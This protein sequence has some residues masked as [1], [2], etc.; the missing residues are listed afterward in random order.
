MFLSF[1]I[2]LATLT[3][4]SYEICWLHFSCHSQ[5]SCLNLNE[6]H[7]RKSNG[8]LEK[9]FCWLKLEVIIV[10]IK[11]TYIYETVIYEI[12]DSTKWLKVCIKIL[13]MTLINY[14]IFHSD[15]W[16]CFFG[17]HLPFINFLLLYST[18]SLTCNTKILFSYY[19]ILLSRSRCI[20]H[21]SLFLTARKQA[22]EYSICIWLLKSIINVKAW[23]ENKT[24]KFNK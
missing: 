3:V 24:F 1:F 21:L 19:F 18:N 11:C 23:S 9:L 2:M 10:I 16:H 8:R 20:L 7:F 12:F 15:V 4:L 6:T 5:H 22:S 13:C 14:V 17:I